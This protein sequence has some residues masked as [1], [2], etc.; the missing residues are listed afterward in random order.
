[1]EFTAQVVGARWRVAAR[2]MLALALTAGAFGGGGRSLASEPA[3]AVMVLDASGSMWGQIDGEP[4]I[5]IAR[6]VIDGLITEWDPG[7][8]LGLIAY[9][10]R[11]KGDCG[12]IETLLTPGPVDANAFN[13]KVKSLNPKGMTPIT[14]AVRKAANDLKYTEQKATVI[15]VSDGLETCDADPCA[16]A[17]ELE[18]SGVDF[19]A[20]VVGFDVSDEEREQLRCIADETGGEFFSAANAGEL[21]GA[22]AGTLASVRVEIERQGVLAMAKRCEDCPTLAKGLIWSVFDVSPSTGEKTGRAVKS[23]GASQPFIGLDAGDYYLEVRHGKVITGKNITIE[24][25]KTTEEAFVLGSGVLNVTSVLTQ[26]GP[27]LERGLIYRVREKGREND[28]AV[29]DSSGAAKAAFNLPEGDYSVEV[30]HGKATASAPLSIMAG[31]ETNHE[32]VLNAGYLTAE[33]RRVEGGDVV[34]SKLLWRVF[35]ANGQSIEAQRAFDS[36]GAAGPRFT[37]PSGDYVLQAT[38]GKATAETPV[39]IVAAE[40]AKG[41]VVLNAGRIVLDAVLTEGSQ[42]LTSKLMWRIFEE[43]SA[44]ERPRAFDSSGAAKATFLLPAG[45]YRA[46]ATFGKAVVDKTVTV[47]ADGEASQTFVLNAGSVD[48]ELV[49]AAGNRLSSGIL[50]RVSRVGDENVLDSS[51]ASRPTFRLPAG[52]Y[53]IRARFDGNEFDGKFSIA[54]GEK[55][56][57]TLKSE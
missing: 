44:D 51:G 47:S 40:T 7:V 8:E 14:E 27:S 25:E 4:K 35:E 6:Q 5:S 50:W 30:T 9:G 49:D 16:L 3:R 37:L 12:D 31:Q 36:S 1:M 55:T 19:T 45:T 34:G 26:D 53:T 10:H 13:T 38:Y 23:S 54:A 43:T 56:D 17:G 52:D 48:A 20:H 22:L 46:Q 33:A 2:L 39:T 29:F 18:A 42:P 41:E 15:L 28:S 11:A 24:S 21:G 32:F 57:V